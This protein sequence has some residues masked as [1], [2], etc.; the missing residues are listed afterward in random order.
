[1][2]IVRSYI[3]GAIVL[4]FLF[5]NIGFEVFK[6]ICREDGVTVAYV[7]NT[8]EHCDEHVED[9]P[10]CCQEKHDDK[11]CCDD[12]VSFYQIKLDYFQKNLS[13]KFAQIDLTAPAPFYAPEFPV[14]E[15]RESFRVAYE[16]PP[17]IEHN[18]R[19][20]ILQVFTI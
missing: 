14:Y 11:G 3:L 17:P 13:L 10:P 8:I 9:L 15:N 5:G 2:Q 1:M 7:I 18:R 20:A 4:L 16:D 19:Q 12:E 6:H